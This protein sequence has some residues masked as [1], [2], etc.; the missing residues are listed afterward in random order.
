MKIL[1]LT[2]SLAFG[3]DGLADYSL[4]LAG[5][6][7]RR[8]HEAALFGWRGHAGVPTDGESRSIPM[9]G[10]AS[11]GSPWRR[12]ASAIE[13][14]QPDWVSAQFVTFGYHPRGLPFEFAQ[15]LPSAIGGRKTQLM[16]HEIWSGLR[17][18][19]RWRESLLGALQRWLILRMVRR[20]RPAALHTSIEYYRRLLGRSKVEAKLLPIFGNVPVTE[21]NADAWL[22]PLLPEPCRSAGGAILI[23]SFGSIHNPPVWIELLRR[24]NVALARL[25]RRACVA[26]VG[27]RGRGSLLEQAA[28]FER[29]HFLELGM[30]PAKEVDQIL[31]S[32]HFGLAT[33]P[34]DALGKSSS[35]IAMAEHGLPLLVQGGF[36]LSAI[37]LPP[38][39]HMALVDLDKREFDPSMPRLPR[40]ALLESTADALLADLH[41]AHFHP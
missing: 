31:N 15:R 24:V 25:G 21:A 19:K 30:R 41:A 18:D 36:R 1:F 27:G 6:L 3:R 4:L 16:L 28:S 23:C 22:T 5:E 35:A 34:M 13:E 14:F 9:L 37:E 20:L 29:I 40:R 38:P 7:R 39:P 12:W 10:E 17:V 8:G 11:N 26:L 33:T 2:P 32:C